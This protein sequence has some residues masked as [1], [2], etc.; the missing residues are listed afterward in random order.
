MNSTPVV[1]RCL[2]FN[3]PVEIRPALGE[4]EP[5]HADMLRYDTAFHSPDAP[6]LV[7]FPRFKHKRHGIM[8]DKITERRWRSFS[9]TLEEIPNAEAVN[10]D[11]WIGYVHDAPTYKLRR[12]TLREYLAE[13]ADVTIYAWR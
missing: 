5:L 10:V 9:C 13:N 11:D 6:S 12:V 4:T 8:P 2:H 7:I 3:R 1:Y